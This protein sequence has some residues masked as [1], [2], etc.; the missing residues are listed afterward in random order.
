MAR[1]SGPA[2]RFRRG[3]GGRVLPTRWPDDSVDRGGSGDDDRSR[4]SRYGSLLAGRQL[5]G[6]HQGGVEERGWV[7]RGHEGRR[8]H[9]VRG[10]TAR[11]R[12]P[13]RIRPRGPGCLASAVVAHRDGNQI[14]TLGKVR[15]DQRGQ[16]RRLPAGHCRLLVDAI[17]RSRCCFLASEPGSGDSGRLPRHGR[18][19][20]PFQVSMGARSFKVVHGSTRPC[21]STARPK[22]RVRRRFWHGQPVAEADRTLLATASSFSARIVGPAPGRRGEAPPPQCR[23]LGRQ[24]GPKDTMVGRLSSHLP[25]RNRGTQARRS[26]RPWR[27]WSCG[28]GRSPRWHR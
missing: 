1:G 25:D 17:G 2:L 13:A 18:L 14:P 3:L 16:N 20:H 7:P 26:G 5:P 19:P 6:F 8:G 12:I 27:R 21:R 10:A 28:P 11:G 23:R 22:P 24:R 15:W 9:L 4:R